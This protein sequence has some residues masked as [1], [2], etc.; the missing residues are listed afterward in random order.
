[1]SAGT[2]QTIGAPAV[3]DTS[4]AQR[5]RTSHPPPPLVF[6]NCFAPLHETEHDAVIVG[7]SI[8]QH[9]CAS[10]VKGKVHTHCFPGACVLDVSVQIPL[11]DQ[12]STGAVVLHAGDIDTKLQQ[13]ET[14]KRDFRSLIEMVT[15]AT[16]S[17]LSGQMVT[18]VTRIQ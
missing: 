16:R 12:E 14:L 15:I 10:L 6:K 13:T 2:P 3:E 8:I 4:Q 5:A 17:S 11:K 9:V 18:A 7:D 1:S